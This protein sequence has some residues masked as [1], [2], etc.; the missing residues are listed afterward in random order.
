MKKI[1]LASLFLLSALSRLYAQN[2]LNPG[3]ESWTAGDPA[4]WLTNNF[5]GAITITQSSDAHSGS[6]S[7]RAEVINFN[8]TPY[9]PVLASDSTYGFPMTQAF[10]T[11]EFWYK[12]NSVSN[13]AIDL[14][15]FVYDG[16]HSL[17]GFGGTLIGTSASSY[18]HAAVPITYTGSN[19]ASC[20]L[21]FTISDTSAGSAGTHIGTYFLLDD[22]TMTNSSSGVRE[23]KIDSYSLKAF[24]NP[25]RT[26]TILS[27]SL[28]TSSSVTIGLFD[29]TGRKMYART[30]IGMSAG[31]QEEIIDVSEL[32]AGKY[33]C[34]LRTDSGTAST[35][36]E[37]VK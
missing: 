17:V 19:P 36:V 9:T 34:L 26:N 16:A 2:V 7:A 18:T 31:N 33:I 35:M 15:A 27:Y 3:F 28:K 6:S 12:L 21:Y 20:V 32:S 24:P 10:T 13:D 5:T 11:L 30:H 22:V 23:N 29:L 4:Y 25:S 37:V 8:G 1:L 14:F